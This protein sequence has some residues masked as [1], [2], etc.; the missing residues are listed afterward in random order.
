MHFPRKEFE[1]IRVLA[2]APGKVFT[3]EELL[4]EVWGTDVYVTNRTVDVHIRKIRK[5]LGSGYVE[6][7]TGVGYRLNQPTDGG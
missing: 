1:L 7:I 4:D 3:R 5:K 2:S 6:T